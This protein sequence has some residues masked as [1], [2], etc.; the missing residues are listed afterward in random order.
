MASQMSY[1]IGFILQGN[2]SAVEEIN[3]GTNWKCYRDS[4]YHPLPVELVYSYYVAGPGELVDMKRQPQKWQKPDFD[5][6]KWQSAS[7]ISTGW[8][9]G[10]FT[11]DDGWMLVPSPILRS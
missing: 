11:F 3:T 7:K 10:L 6:T 4:A 1:R 5:D 8:P 2:T 9:K